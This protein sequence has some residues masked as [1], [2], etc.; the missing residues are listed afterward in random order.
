MISEIRKDFSASAAIAGLIAL[1]ATYSG[2]VLILVEAAKA[3]NLSPG[4]LSTWIFAVSIGAGITGLYLSLKFK[5][6]VI[7]AWSTPGVALLIYGLTV[8]PFNEVVGCYLILTILVT[9]IG[10]SGLFSRLISILPTHLL[11]AMIAGVLFQ[12][13]VKIFQSLQD[14]PNI[15]LPIVVSYVI[16]RRLLPRYAV[17]IALLIGILFSI[18]NLDLTHSSINLSFVSPEMTL[19]SFSLNALLG[20]GLPLFLLSLTQFA[21]S[22]HILRNAGYDVLPTKI[23]GFN[24]LV[25]IPLSLFGSSGS[26]PAA[27]VGALCASAECHDDLNKRYI[28]GLVCGAGYILIGIFGASIVSLFSLL[29]GALVTSLAG[30]ALLGTLVSSLTSA[31]SDEKHRDPSLITFLVTVSGMSFLGLGSAL[32]GLLFGLIFSVAMSWKPGNITSWFNQSYLSR[33]NNRK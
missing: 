23:V 9:L 10:Y 15:V 30:L 17:A 28:S 7:G 18:P 29:P 22:I 2:P 4:I 33:N 25:S 5:V 12:F 20:L 11:S 14:F 13:C 21:T 8:Y 16:F 32:W 6:P 3:G 27:I 24:G 19:P 26:N 1:M 31:I